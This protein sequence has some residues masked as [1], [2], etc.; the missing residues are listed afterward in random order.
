[1]ADDKRIHD[2]D[3]ELSEGT[4]V[5]HLIEL[6]QRLMKAFGAVVVIFLPLLL[7]QE[8]IFNIVSKPLRDTLPEGSIP[9]AIG[10]I[11]PFMMPLKT[12]FYV[13]LFLAMPVVLY[14]AWRF[15][16]PGLYR[17]EKRFGVPLVV[18]SIV[19]FYAGIA[20]AY[21]VV[22]KLVFAFIFSVA[23]DTIELAPDINE[24]LSFV[25]RMFL[26]FGLAFET[27]IATFMLVWTR[28]VSI[29]TLG[30]ARPYV[31][32]GAFIVGMFL[33]PPDMF[34]QTMLAIPIYILYE[35][36]ILLARILLRD[37]LEEEKETEEESGSDETD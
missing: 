37:R 13:G 29:K 36:G 5:S 28:L 32:L 30:K 6:R 18:S 9:Q 10:V 15:V 24:Y 1:M 12:T 31:F 35:A 33:T 3:E 23:P 25:L 26:A 27:P 19:L 2:E 34:S 20:F 17:G 22:F 4:L 7:V 14:Q 8:E 16:A 11:S 21:F